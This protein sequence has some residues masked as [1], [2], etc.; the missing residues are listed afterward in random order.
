MMEPNLKAL[1]PFDIH[2]RCRK[3]LLFVHPLGAA[4]VATDIRRMAATGYPVEWNHIGEGGAETSEDGLDAFV[5][6]KRSWPDI[7][8]SDALRT[9]LEDQPMG[10]HLYITAPWVWV[11]SIVRLAETVGYAK[12]DIQVR[13]FGQ[14]YHHVFCIACYTTNPIDNASTVTCR[15][16]GRVISVSD[17]YSPRWDAVMGYPILDNV[18]KKGNT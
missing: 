14:K 15:Q 1:A 11:R 12:E 9:Y 18:T 8:D 10:T 5:S 16:C 7:H 2:S 3:H 13:G 17:H 6:A 4:H